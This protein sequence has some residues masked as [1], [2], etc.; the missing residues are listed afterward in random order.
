MLRLHPV[1]LTSGP[2]HSL[3]PGTAQQLAILLS[4]ASVSPTV[5]DLVLS[6][7]LSCCREIEARSEPKGNLG[8]RQSEFKY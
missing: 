1:H 8:K 6:K 5:Y 4:H 2:L 3:A 7:F